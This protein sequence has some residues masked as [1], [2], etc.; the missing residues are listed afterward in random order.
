M[1]DKELQRLRRSE[2]LEILLSQ[3]K[4]IESLKKELAE[5]KKGIALLGGGKVRVERYRIP[6]TDV[7]HSAV[8]I[9]K[10]RPTPAKYPRRYAQI[11]KQPL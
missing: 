3:Q 8:L 1:T 5:A 2:L 6:G 10:L 4:Q 7:I 9:E 11:K